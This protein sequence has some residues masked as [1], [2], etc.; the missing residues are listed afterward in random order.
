M[1]RWITLLAI[2]AATFCGSP[3]CGTYEYRDPDQPPENDY[4]APPPAGLKTNPGRPQNE[5]PAPP[6][7]T[8]P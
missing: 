5:R 8:P 2:A 7:P 3:G 1:F 4:Q 6:N